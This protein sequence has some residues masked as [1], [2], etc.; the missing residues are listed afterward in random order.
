MKVLGIHNMISKNSEYVLSK[1]LII[2]TISVIQERTISHKYGIH[3]LSN[4]EGFILSNLDS[5]ILD[6]ALF[7]I[8]MSLFGNLKVNNIKVSLHEKMFVYVRDIDP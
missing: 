5:T 2:E 3:I 4:P 8:M 1:M 6:A 7:V